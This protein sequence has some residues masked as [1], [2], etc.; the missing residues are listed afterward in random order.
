MHLLKVDMIDHSLSFKFAA[1]PL[2]LGAYRSGSQEFP[3]TP[4][5][6]FLDNRLLVEYFIY[7]PGWCDQCRVILIVALNSF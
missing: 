5:G 4:S 3:E 1:R 7:F 6:L 2:I